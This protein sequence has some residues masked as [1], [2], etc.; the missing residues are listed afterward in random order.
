MAQLTCKA[1]KRSKGINQ[2]SVECYQLSLVL[3]CEHYLN[4]LQNWRFLDFFPSLTLLQVSP[5][6]FY[7]CHHQ[8]SHFDTSTCI[9]S[10]F[11]HEC[12]MHPNAI[13]N[14][15][16]SVTSSTVC[17]CIYTDILPIFSR[18]FI[19]FIASLFSL[20]FFLGSPCSVQAFIYALPFWRVLGRYNPFDTS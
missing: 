11:L 19:F 1:S 20:S 15:K 18:F 4:V 2:K 17:L 9:A 10:T 14:Y 8:C 13:H 5:V 12:S 7:R 6:L 3:D 16:Y